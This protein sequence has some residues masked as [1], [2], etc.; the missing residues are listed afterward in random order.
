MDIEPK[1]GSCN[2]VYR[3]GTESHAK[4]YFGLIE[5]LL[6]INFFF[7][8]IETTEPQPTTLV[9]GYDIEDLLSSWVTSTR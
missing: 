5:T 6:S 4:L 7:Q 2:N 8:I 3:Y 9:S 1:V